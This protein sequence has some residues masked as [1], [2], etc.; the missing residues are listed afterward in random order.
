VD[1]K[2][3]IA[4]VTPAAHS[5]TAPKLR[6][7]VKPDLE[8]AFFF[9]WGNCYVKGQVVDDRYGYGGALKRRIENR[10][11]NTSWMP[12]LNILCNYSK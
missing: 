9:M 1:A 12:V 3:N 2:L 5:R 10:N 8:E 6:T 4:S 11:R 7:L